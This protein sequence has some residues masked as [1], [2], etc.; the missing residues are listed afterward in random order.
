[1]TINGPFV[2]FASIGRRQ[3]HRQGSDTMRLR[4]AYN[5]EERRKLWSATRKPRQLKRRRRAHGPLNCSHGNSEAAAEIQRQPLY[6]IAFTPISLYNSISVSTPPRR[7]VRISTAILLVLSRVRWIE[8]FFVAIT[9][10]A[11]PDEIVVDSFNKALDYLGHR[12]SATH[13]GSAYS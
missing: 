3:D 2:Y 6:F 12:G 8:A 5:R 4:H 9:L 13:S 1:M 10:Q 7:I 11:N